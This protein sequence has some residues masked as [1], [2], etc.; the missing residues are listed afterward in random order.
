MFLELGSSL[1]SYARQRQSTQDFTIARRRFAF[2]LTSTVT[3]RQ[4]TDD[5]RQAGSGHNRPFEISRQIVNNLLLS[6]GEVAS[7]HG[8]ATKNFAGNQERR[9]L[10]QALSISSR[11][12]VCGAFPDNLNQPHAHTHRSHSGAPSMVTFRTVAVVRPSSSSIQSVH[13]IP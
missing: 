4:A 9:A 8:S 1:I 12:G 10:A 13:V 2:R 3:Y 7:V 11:Q 5:R 6:F